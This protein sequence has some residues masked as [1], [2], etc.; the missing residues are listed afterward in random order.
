MSIVIIDYGM[1]NT[2]S[3]LNMLK[4]LQIDAIISASPSDIEKA[5]KIILPGVG[6]FDHGINQLQKHQLIN[7][8]NEQILVR[9]KPILGICLGL[10]LMTNSSEEGVLPGLG[11]LDAQTLKFKINPDTTI[12]IP[13]IGWNLLEPL[14]QHPLLNDLQ[15]P[16]KYYFVHSYYLSCNNPA[17][18]VGVTYHGQRFDALV[19]HENIMGCQFH[20]EKSHRFGMKIFENFNKI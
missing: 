14:Q 10:Q 9:K 12:R 19:A 17:D 16:S 3:I 1:G 11:W 5:D 6:A 18:V 13:H 4:F 7:S 8:L 2:G 15:H 20:P